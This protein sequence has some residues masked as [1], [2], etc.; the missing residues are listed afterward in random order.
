[1]RQRRPGNGERL[2]LVEPERTAR[3]ETQHDTDENCRDDAN[4]R[5]VASPQDAKLVRLGG[6]LLEQREMTCTLRAGGLAAGHR[7]ELQAAPSSGAA[8]S[9]VSRR[10][11]TGASR[12]VLP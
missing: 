10:G 8:T 2:R 7:H 4:G 3:D 12:P 6:A 11:S 5:P 1:M 9:A